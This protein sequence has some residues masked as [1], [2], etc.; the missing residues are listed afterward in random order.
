[1]T[2]LEAELATQARDHEAQRAEWEAKLTEGERRWEGDRRRAADQAQSELEEKLRGVQA[3]VA[4]QARQLEEYQV[5]R[6]GQ[7]EE[8]RDLAEQLRQRDDLID[9]LEARVAEAEMEAA[10]AALKFAQHRDALEEQT[11]KKLQQ[12]YEFATTVKSAQ[13]QRA[14]SEEAIADGALGAN[15]AGGDGGVFTPRSHLKTEQNRVRNALQVATSEL[16][17]IRAEQRAVGERLRQSRTLFASM[18]LLQEAHAAL[19]EQTVKDGD[20]EAKELEEWLAL[21]EVERARSVRA[22]RMLHLLVPPVFCHCQYHYHYH[23]HYHLHHPTTTRR[24][25]SGSR[26][27]TSSRPGGVTSGSSGNSMRRGGSCRRCAPGR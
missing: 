7:D 11:E 22:H 19:L 13:Q 1:M 6:D 26:A 12:A 4:A 8:R 20:K 10:D 16:K 23:Y 15:S 24:K 14:L 27:S 25:R 21:N 9:D 17:G 3:Q 2:E 5:L 18:S